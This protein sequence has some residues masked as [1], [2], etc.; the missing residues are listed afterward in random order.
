MRVVVL[1]AV[2][3]AAIARP[4]A[5][6]CSAF[7]NTPA[8]TNLQMREEGTHTVLLGFSFRFQ[9]VL[10]DR[11]TIADNG[12][13][14]LGAAPVSGASDF[15]PTAAEMLSQPPRLSVCW[16][17]LH[18]DSFLVP[19][20]GGVFFRTDG[21]TANVVWKSVPR[22]FHQA[23]FANMELVLTSDTHPTNRNEIAFVYDGAMM[24]M[25]GTNIVGITRGAGAPTPPATQ[26]PTVA[27]SAFAPAVA[28]GGTAYQVFTAAN[29]ATP[30]NLVGQTLRFVPTDPNAAVDHA[31]SIAPLATCAPL[32]SYPPTATAPVAFGVG[33][34]SPIPSSSIYE[35]FS[36]NTGTQ[37]FDLANTSVTFFR[38]GGA[39]ITFAGPAFDA[40][41]ATSGTPLT[42]GDDSLVSGLSLGAMGTFSFGTSVVST[43]TVCSNG[44]LWLPTPTG[45]G[46][47]FQPT[48]AALNSELPRIAP[49]WTDLNSSA[50]GGGTMYWENTNPAFCRLTFEN[51]RE[52]NQAASANTFQVTL[53]STGDIA[54]AYAGMSGGIAHPIVVGISGGGV[55]V[56][57]GAFD[58]ATGGTVNVLQRTIS[59]QQAMVHTLPGRCQLGFD[60][61]LESTV[62]AP[63][64]GV[65]VFVIGVASP[66]APLDFLGAPGCSLYATLDNLFFVTVPSSPMSLLVPVPPT[67]SFAGAALFSQAAALSTLNAFGII[68]SNGQS[69]TV[70]I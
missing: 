14:W 3:L 30:F 44:F 56:D 22:F 29:G 51:V 4:S 28:T 25:T 12:Y 33:C 53:F 37:P 2:V 45:T 47:S 5:A 59:A 58:F 66:S 69:F 61:R 35:S 55:A 36:V 24:P 9:N 15:T 42:G 62:P 63:L 7:A 16:D 43:I 64:S 67:P 20:G 39:Y 8:G 26:P 6:Q 38:T 10:Y 11:I 21:A 23:V 57:P 34:P 41:Y 50:T 65:G 1:L 19:P 18:S 40:T 46:T 31:V 32:A 52:F 49:F 13:V 48:A 54:F 70:G 68:A 60:F 27:W 17:D